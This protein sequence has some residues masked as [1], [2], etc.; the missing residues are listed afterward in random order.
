MIVYLGK[1]PAI[2]IP[3]RAVKRSTPIPGTML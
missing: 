2:H 1:Q 3:L